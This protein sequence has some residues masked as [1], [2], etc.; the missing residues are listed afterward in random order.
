[1]RCIIDSTST[2]SM[3]RYGKIP[4]KPLRETFC[5]DWP[6]GSSVLKG[7]STANLED[8]AFLLTPTWGSIVGYVYLQISLVPPPNIPRCF[9]K[10]S[11]SESNLKPV[12]LFGNPHNQASRS[13]PFV[14]G[15]LYL[16]CDLMLMLYSSMEWNIRSESIYGTEED[17]KV[18]RQKLQEVRRWRDALPL[19]MRDDINFTPQT[20]YLRC[21]TQPYHLAETQALT[22]IAQVRIQMRCSSAY[23]DLSIR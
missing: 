17:L 19:N 4:P 22:R 7:L 18:R 14:P 6:G 9:E 8:E 2:A 16:A 20:C 11:V 10:P 3:M 5:L 1:M 13:P 12:D 15:A 21:V 23:C